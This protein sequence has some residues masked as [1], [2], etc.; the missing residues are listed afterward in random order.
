MKFQLWL[1]CVCA[2]VALVTCHEVK[3]AF[4]DI[5]EAGFKAVDLDEDGFL[6]FSEMY[7]QSKEQLKETDPKE[8]NECIPFF[9]GMDSDK[10]GKITLDEWKK[11]KLVFDDITEAG[12]KAVDLDEDGFLSFSEIKQSREQLKETDPKEANAVFDGMD[13][14]KDGKITLDEW[15]KKIANDSNYPLFPH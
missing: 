11:K 9:D 13:S 8:A 3:S 4:E 5:T 10:D 2:A 7:G 1:L 15:K 14:D 12:F 6:S